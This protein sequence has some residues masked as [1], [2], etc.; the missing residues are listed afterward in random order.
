M[1][2]STQKSQLNSHGLFSTP[3]AQ[4]LMDIFDRETSL[5]SLTNMGLLYT[6]QG[7]LM[8]DVKSNLKEVKKWAEKAKSTLENYIQQC[9]S[10]DEVRL[11][12]PIE[13]PKTPRIV[14]D[15][16][17]LGVFTE[18]TSRIRALKN[19]LSRLETHSV[20][21]DRVENLVSYAEKIIS[22]CD[23]VLSK[24]IMD[25]IE[26]NKPHNSLSM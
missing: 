26:S 3:K 13:F 24:P 8:S 2:Q 1:T 19:I 11:S 16:P 20:T 18:K 21:P 15:M 7:N 5:N 4:H 9:T 10:P 17:D 6:P 23:A 14:E 25:S 12:A 22:R